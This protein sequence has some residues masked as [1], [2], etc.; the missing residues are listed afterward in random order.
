MGKV[1]FRKGMVYP[2]SRRLIEIIERSSWRLY[3]TESP[4]GKPLV[5][6][7]DIEQQGL[8]KEFIIGKNYV[9]APIPKNG[10]SLR[11]AYALTKGFGPSLLITDHREDIWSDVYLI[12]G[13]YQMGRPIIF[14]RLAFTP[15]FLMAFSPKTRDLP[16]SDALAIAYPKAIDTFERY[17]RVIPPE[18]EGL[19]TPIPMPLH[20]ED[21]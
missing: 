19:R 16:D 11:D 6:W 21:N 15:E 4:N 17:F 8:A 2:E 20:A 5:N 7:A 14:T 1:Q 18:E 3:G 13:R 10:Q 9:F 12:S